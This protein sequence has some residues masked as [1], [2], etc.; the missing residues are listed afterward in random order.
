[1]MRYAITG[2]QEFANDRIERWVWAQLNHL[3]ETRPIAIGLSCL[4]AGTDQIFADLIIAKGIPLCAIIPSRNYDST[5]ENNVTLKAYERLSGLA[6]NLVELDFPEPSE[7][8]FFSA[9]K[10]MVQRSDVL[11]AVWD[12]QPSKGL[13]GTADV[14]SYAKKLG[15][16]V[17]HLN[18]DNLSQTETNPLAIRPA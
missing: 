14:V 3:I 11:I 10:E 12:A 13:G 9:S 5:F 15:N 2:H 6:A 7:G 4:A 1:M 8:A 16:G 17:I 18:P